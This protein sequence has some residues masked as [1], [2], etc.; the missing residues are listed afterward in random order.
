MPFLLSDFVEG[1]IVARDLGSVDFDL[2]I[3]DDSFTYS[4]STG[5]NTQE[6][7]SELS[8][9][10][11]DSYDETI[12]NHTPHVLTGLVAVFD[13]DGSGEQPLIRRKKRRDSVA[14]T[15]LAVTLEFSIGLVP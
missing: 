15:A 3:I 14:S 2:P 13:D 1:K 11:H 5:S 7:D 10:V 12:G 9:R 6:E 8:I 4:G